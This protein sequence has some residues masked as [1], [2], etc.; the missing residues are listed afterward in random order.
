MISML[1]ADSKK[2]EG[3]E[4]LRC[5]RELAALLSEEKWNYECLEKAAQLTQRLKEDPQKDLAC[6]DVSME[7]S[8]EAM[9]LIRRHNR[10]ASL[11][12]IASPDI[13]PASYIRPSILPSSILI[14]PIT[15]EHLRQTMEETFRDFL[16]RFQEEETEDAFVVETREGRIL[17]DKSQILYFEARE[18]KIFLNT[19]A[20]EIPFYDTMENLEQKLAQG[21]L[22]C[23]RG[24]LV[25]IDKIREI[26]YAQNRIL[27][28]DD[29][30]VP[31]SR[32][33]KSKIKA[34]SSARKL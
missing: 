22:R 20:R 25:N 15:G 33:Y 10:H 29:V 28:T 9:S 16:A 3:Q 1:I 24:Y 2:A 32:G 27:L 17:V 21:F 14:R 8:I 30:E 31:L 18:K 4:I 5:A 19:C 23:H 6:M 26:Q 12:V 11:T 7:G 13:S 34:N